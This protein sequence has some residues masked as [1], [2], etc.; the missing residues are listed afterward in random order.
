MGALAASEAT[1]I[2][3]TTL[4][5]DN[6]AAEGAP[7]VSAPPAHGTLIAKNSLIFLSELLVAYEMKKP[8]SWLPGDRIVRKLWWVSPAVMSTIHFK[9]AAHN[10]ALGGQQSSEDECT[11]VAACES[12]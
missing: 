11:S 9:A 10:I 12:Q 2:T 4:V 6:E 3:T 8:H 5:L 7:W 1:R